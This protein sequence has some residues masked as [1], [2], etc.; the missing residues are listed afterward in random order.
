MK[1]LIVVNPEAGKYRQRSLRQTLEEELAA[2]GHTWTF[3]E[4]RSGE[5]LGTV[6]RR[7]VD[8]GVDVVVAAGGD[9]TVAGVADGLVDTG[10]SLAII[11]LG[12][13]NFVARELG[14]PQT[15]RGAAALLAGDHQSVSIDAMRVEGRIYV[16]NVGVGISAGVIGDTTSESKKRLGFVA[17]VL[18][19]IG[20]LLTMKA[21]RL[22]V[23]VDGRAHAYRAVEV[24]VN[25]CGLPAKRLYPRT[26]DIRLDDGHL[27]AWVMST[28]ALS[29]YPRYVLA[30]ILG[31]TPKLAARFIP[32]KQRV[33]ID[34]PAPLFVQADGDIIGRTPV[35]IEV[36]P[37]ALTVLA[38]VEQ[39][40]TLQTSLT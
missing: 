4:A 33:R 37:G 38:P 32:V 39:A 24:L 25:N 36:L 12:T 20:K 13:A 5:H 8:E 17:Y 2:A 28:E 19:T 6:V 9:G 10:V 11:P 29:D 18:T 27:D 3:H 23:V 40:S 22:N 15:V 21:R 14:I 30:T 7:H 26:P 35:E 31:R 1:A 16:L 34:S